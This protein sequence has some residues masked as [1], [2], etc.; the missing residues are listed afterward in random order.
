MRDI[1]A[2]L[3]LNAQ[4]LAF[5]GFNGVFVSADSKTIA[6]RDLAAGPGGA[7]QPWMLKLGVPAAITQ[8]TTA[9]QSFTERLDQITNTV[10][11]AS[12]FRTIV[13]GLANGVEVAEQTVNAAFN[14]AQ[15]NAAAN[16]VAAQLSAFGDGRQPRRFRVD[17][18]VRVNRTVADTVLS[19]DVRDVDT[20]GAS[21]SFTYV[22][23]TPAV[24]ATGDLGVCANPG[25]TGMA[26]SGCSNPGVA[27]FITRGVSNTNTHTVTERI[28][29]RT[30]TRNVAEE[31]FE[32][33][34]ISGVSGNQIGTVHA[35]A[36][37]TAFDHARR[38]LTLL[39]KAKPPAA[40]A[41]QYASATV[42]MSDASAAPANRRAAFADAYGG[43]TRLDADAGLG[44]AESDAEDAGAMA[45]LV[46][47]Q[48]NGWTFGGAIGWGDAEFEVN[49]PVSRERLE[50]SIY[51]GGLFARWRE[52]PWSAGLAVSYGGGDIDTA[53]G[54]G[55]PG[56]VALASRDFDM[57][58]VAGRIGY[59]VVLD[60]TVLTPGL[61]AD[62]VQADLDPFTETG[63]PL[64]LM[65]PGT[66]VD[67]TRVWL[68][69]DVM[70]AFDPRQELTG[71]MYVRAVYADGDVTG[72]ADVAFVSAPNVPLTAL[73]PDVGEF[74]IEIGGGLDFAIDDG[75]TGTVSY[76]GRFG[77]GVESQAVNAGVRVAF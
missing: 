29:T 6:G 37:L 48:G 11:Q 17:N 75:V 9:S 45:G 55:A 47:A 38:F 18:P 73:G 74:T 69:L 10:R 60:G 70:H 25:S 2:G 3:G 66:D 21:R 44:I 36:G 64:P 54:I 24:I 68:G 13:N 4:G 65:S 20:L 14:S 39:L 72:K 27:T 34:N 12:T 28:K 7:S 53:V 31:V 23:N 57:W 46:L 19:T 52:G 76:D 61:G 58:A 63:G 22:N 41:D 43:R 77:D 26:P 62:W 5:S 67:S 15:G 56:G 8:T 42:S 32:E 33:W 59:D 40:D 51:Q 1:V 71:R 16:T 50:Q 30:T 49:D 35:L